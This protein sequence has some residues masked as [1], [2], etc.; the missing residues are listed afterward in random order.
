M[1][2]R[3]KKTY[4]QNIS[5]SKIGRLIVLTGARQTGKTTLIK[6]CF[7]KC[8]YISMEDPVVRPT[9]SRMSAAEWISNYPF[10]I[11]DEV[12]KSPKVVES[13]KA[14]YDMSAQVRYFLLGSSQILLL[15][16]V[17]ESLAGRVII[18]DLFPLTLP[19]ITT[20]S[21]EEQIYE[22]KLISWIKNGVKEEKTITGIPLTNVSYGLHKSLFEYYLKFGSM[23]ALYA[24]DLSDSEKYL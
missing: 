9:Y 1:K 24:T 7:P 10:A 22:S 17:K 23:P 13:I 16:K 19:E 8:P 11:I 4:I 6:E 20:N 14:A 18:E 12:Q 21:W 3:T 15:K 5:T 2:N